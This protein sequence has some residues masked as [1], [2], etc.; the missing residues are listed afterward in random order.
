MVIRVYKVANL[1]MVITWIKLAD[2][3]T[4]ENNVAAIFGDFYHYNKLLEGE[5]AD[6]IMI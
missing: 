5:D 4:E 1:L 3:G 6:T 2:L